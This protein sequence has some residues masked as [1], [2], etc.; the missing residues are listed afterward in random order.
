MG[1]YKTV[2]FTTSNL[3]VNKALGGGAVYDLGCYQI[4]LV[5]N[6]VKGMPEKI[7]VLADI[8]EETGC[9][10]SSSIVLLYKRGFMATLHCAFNETYRNRF[11]FVG[12]KGRIISND[13]FNSEG[14]LTLYIIRENRIKKSKLSLESTG[15]IEKEIINTPDNYTL[16]ISNFSDCIANNK[17]PLLSL[18]SSLE[19]YKILDKVLKIFITN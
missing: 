3:R 7:T 17:R 6:F 1:I 8:C 15:H 2:G 4:N 13:G 16:E 12:D 11:E 9:D 10:K 18:E 5:E 19:T 14:N